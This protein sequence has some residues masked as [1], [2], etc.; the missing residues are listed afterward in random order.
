MSLNFTPYS[1]YAATI[2]TSLITQ[3]ESQDLD[4]GVDEML[5]QA[6]G[7]LYP[8]FAAVGAQQPKLRFSTS[9]LNQALTGGISGFSIAPSG[10][11]ATSAKFYWRPYTQNGGFAAG[12]VNLVTNM[13]LGLILPRRLT[14]RTGEKAIV[15]LE[16][17]PIWD[18]TNNPFTFTANQA[19]PSGTQGVSEIH[20]S[21]PA[22]INGT[23]VYGIEEVSVDFGI[24]DMLFK[25]DGAAFNTFAGW[26]S[27]RPKIT[28]SSKDIGVISAFFTPAAISATTTIFLRSVTSG[29]FRDADSS[30]THVALT[31]TAGMV[32]AVSG[33]A[34]TGEGGSGQ[35]V[36]T[37]IWDGTNSP[38][39]ISTA[40]AITGAS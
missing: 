24:D 33:S 40:S 7:Q 28:L 16:A 25:T 38:I 22:V 18:G 5:V 31:V 15:E 21:G 20:T 14:A 23:A 13:G 39:Q 27:I 29:G 17:I 12:S 26:G 11:S 6:D 4:A 8:Q 30:T 2:G 3:I 9:K 34:R 1:L 10:G 19:L 35:I 37:P 32:H 36:I